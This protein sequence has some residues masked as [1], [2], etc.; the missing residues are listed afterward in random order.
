PGGRAGGECRGGGRGGGRPLRSG[1]SRAGVG[2]RPRRGSGGVGL[3]VP[4]LESDLLQHGLQD[5]LPDLGVEGALGYPQLG[6]D[7]LEIAAVPADRL[8]DGFAL[9]RLEADGA[10]RRRP[11]VELPLRRGSYFSG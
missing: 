2:L 4:P 10:P 9:D 11:W 3:G 7:A 5:V 1:G 8:R 6:G